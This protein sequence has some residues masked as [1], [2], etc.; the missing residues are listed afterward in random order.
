[1]QNIK[2][3]LSA[4]RANI[5][6]ATPPTAAMRLAPTWAPAPEGVGTGVVSW[7]GVTTGVVLIREEVVVGLCMVVE[8]C[9]VVV[10]G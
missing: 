5:A 3:A 7:V 1:M 4:Y 6:T 9:M 10:L 8:L 2:R